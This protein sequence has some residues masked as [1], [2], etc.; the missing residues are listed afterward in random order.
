MAGLC[1]RGTNVKRRSSITILSSR[2]LHG[3][4]AN[5]AIY[6]AFIMTCLIIKYKLGFFCFDGIGGYAFGGFFQPQYD[7]MMDMN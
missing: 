1:R 6:L 2:V 5:S 7:G 4:L 3:H